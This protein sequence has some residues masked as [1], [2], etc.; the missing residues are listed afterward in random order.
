MFTQQQLADVAGVSVDLV[1][2]LE[3]GL[4]QTAS[5]PYLQRIARAL[6]VD[7]AD[8]I[9]EPAALTSA[10]PSA[11]VVAIRRTLTPVDDLVG[12][13]LVEAE[14]PAIADAQ[15]T[16]DYAWG[17]YWGG[18]YELLGSILP[19]ALLQ[20][21]ATARL[22]N[23]KDR[24]TAH[25]LLARIYWPTGCTLVHLGHTDPAFAAVRL[26]LEAAGQGNNELLAATLR[27]VGRVTLGEISLEPL[28]G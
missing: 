5:I 9:G 19:T 17:S 8:L 28:M 1:R 3:Q 6:D 14:P 13:A 10:D 15:R 16:V 12:E 22:A 2:K 7:L 20:L 27:G 26:A 23:P 18:S 24:P 11:G 21:R 4:R 25:E